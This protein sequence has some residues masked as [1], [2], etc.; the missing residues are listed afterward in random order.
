M[1]CSIHIED[2]SVGFRLYHD[3]GASLKDHLANL[4]SNRNKSYSQF[5]ALEN[6]T[7]DVN[8]G[9]RLGI[10]GHN[11][12]GKSTLLKTIC[13]IYTPTKGKVNVTGRVSPL[14]EIGAGFHLD[15]TGRENIRFNGTLL[16]YS[17]QT[18][19]EIE[20][21]I[22]AFSELEEFI[23]TPVK[24]YSTGMYMRLTFS[25]ATAVHPEILIWD[26][27]FAGGDIGFIEK[28]KKR[29]LDCV[30]NASIV[31]VVSH[32]IDLIRD[33]CD[34][35]ILLEKGRVVSDGDPEKVIKEYYG[36]ES[37]S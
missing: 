1:N 19:K 20:D 14:L 16:G 29:M 34:R 37:L 23:D 17:S 5:N 9:E 36:K 4:W 6:V 3:K 33:L 11:G 26:E 8:H 35:V 30:D 28:A 25:I 7:V 21:E 2:V 27:L 12:A 32:Q 24:Y 18:I 13:N 15:F 10:I 31:I 22:I